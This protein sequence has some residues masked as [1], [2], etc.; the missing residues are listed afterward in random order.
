M[1]TEKWKDGNFII[2]FI[3]GDSHE[4]RAGGRSEGYTNL[5]YF[6]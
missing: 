4:E 6:S 5:N 3:Q 1:S 2:L